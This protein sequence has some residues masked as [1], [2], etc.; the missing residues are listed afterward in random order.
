MKKNNLEVGGR[1]VENVRCYREEIVVRYPLESIRYKDLRYIVDPHIREIVQTRFAEVGNADKDFVKS[2]TERPLYSDKNCRHQIRAIR[3][4][5]GLNPSTLAGVRRD[6][7]GD[8]IGY[9]QTRNNHHLALYRNPDGSI[10]ESVVSFWD[11]IK[12][13]QA[14]LPPI[15][16][17]PAEAWD[18]VIANSESARFA[19][20]ADTLPPDG[21]EF[22]MS[23]Q[24]N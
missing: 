23:L 8:T 4:I 24:R 6:Q 16:K 21:S 1:S 20:I 9:A 19:G 7:S 14:G 2:L 17:N 13:K 3:L 12:R 10:V 5:S 18:T 11:C 15:I 22:I